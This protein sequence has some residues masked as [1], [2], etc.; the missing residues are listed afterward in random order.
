VADD[1]P[2]SRGQDGS[3]SGPDGLGISSRS[4]PAS[5]RERLIEAIEHALLALKG[6]T[7]GLWLNLALGKV[8]QAIERWR[9]ERPSSRPRLQHVLARRGR[10]TVLNEDVERLT[11]LRNAHPG[12]DCEAE[13]VA[14]FGRS[15]HRQ[16]ILIRYRRADEKIIKDSD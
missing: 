1:I 5:S 11:D 4:A 15:L 14:S 12:S 8:E 13:F 9:V 7:D 3:P 16:Q 2:S 10:P 6:D